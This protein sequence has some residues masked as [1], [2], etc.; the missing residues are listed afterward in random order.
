MNGLVRFLSFQW[1]FRIKTQKTL[2]E[3]NLFEIF[4]QLSRVNA[5]ASL[6]IPDVEGKSWIIL[7]YLKA[8]VLRYLAGWFKQS[9]DVPMHTI[10]LSTDFWDCT[11]SKNCTHLHKRPQLTRTSKSCS[12]FPNEPA[13]TPILIHHGGQWP[14]NTKYSSTFWGLGLLR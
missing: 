10:V 11:V 5:T 9:W 12:S 14:Q 1:G 3:I 7:S 8:L 6:I 2:K 13:F 4:Q